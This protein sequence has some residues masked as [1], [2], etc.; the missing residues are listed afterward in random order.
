MDR[1]EEKGELVA[2]VLKKDQ[3]K[4]GLDFLTPDEAFC[5]V[6]TWWYDEGKELRAH[7]HI[8][9]QRPNDLTQEC[10]I[11]MNGSVR[12]DLYDNTDTVFQSVTLAAGDLMVLLH[13]AHGYEIL[14]S[15]TKVIECKNGPFISVDKDKIIL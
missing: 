8:E 5:Q 15:D 12:V 7:R 6:G 4:N 1:I 2:I 3:W 11:V 14:E 13:G 9:N 10:V